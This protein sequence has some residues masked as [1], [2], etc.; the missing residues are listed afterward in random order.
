MLEWLREQNWWKFGLEDHNLLIAAYG[1]LGQ[2]EK[3]SCVLEKMRCA[4]LE[5]NVAVNTSL[6]EAYARNGLFV[7]AES[8]FSQMLEIGPAPTEATYQT[9][10]H[11][12]CKV[13]D[14]STSFHVTIR[15]HCEAL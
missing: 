2:P 15:H 5:P 4:G 7:Q 8:I 11:A 3:A 9:F 1:K 10:I 14:T 6:L 12:L 13:L